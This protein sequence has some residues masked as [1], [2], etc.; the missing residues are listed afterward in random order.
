MLA[1]SLAVANVFSSMSS[2]AV[3][4]LS[5]YPWLVIAALQGPRVFLAAA[6]EPS[7]LEGLATERDLVTWDDRQDC[8]LMQHEWRIGR[9]QLRSKP[10]HDASREMQERVLCDAVAKNGLSMLSWNDDVGALQRRVAQVAAWHPELKIPDLSTPHLLVTAHDWLPY[11]LDDGGRLRTT[12]ATLRKIDLC[13]ALWALIPYDL[14]QQIERLAPSHIVVP[15]GS[16]IR[17]DYRVGAEA[18]VLSVRLQECFGMKETPCVDDGRVPVL[19]ELLSPGYK[20]VQLTSDL[21]SFWQNTYFEVRGE[22][23][24]RYPKHYWPDNPLEAEPTAKVKR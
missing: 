4:L 24:R 1:K 16:R 8:L 15:T 20:P 23:R 17:L 21:G 5:S 19:M 6:V 7:D 2:S 11:Y 3:L 18:P 22:L 13:A 10:I 9:L 14:Q 12:G